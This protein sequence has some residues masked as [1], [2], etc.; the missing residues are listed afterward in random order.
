MMTPDAMFEYLWSQE[1]G[2]QVVVNPEFKKRMVAW[3][4]FA[5][6]DGVR[7]ER[8]ACAK[9]CDEEERYYREMMEE[10]EKKRHAE[11]AAFH[12]TSSKTAAHLGRAIRART[13]GKGALK[14]EG[15]ND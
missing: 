12:H 6:D 15:K 2:H 14:T 8:E 4:R 10:S 3:L 5:Q 13:E 11:G 9:I 7:E 1:F